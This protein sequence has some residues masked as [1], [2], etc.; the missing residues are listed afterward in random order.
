M[1]KGYI[2]LMPADTLRMYA[3]LSGSMDPEHPDKQLSAQD[4]P[5][6]AHPGCPL[7]QAGESLPLY[8]LNQCRD[9]AATVL[10][11]HLDYPSSLRMAR[12]CKLGNM[13]SCG[14]QG[15][16][17]DV[18][19]KPRVLHV[20]E[21][22]VVEDLHRHQ[23]AAQAPVAQQAEEVHPEETWSDQ[24]RMQYLEERRREWASSSGNG[25]KILSM[26][27]SLGNGLRRLIRMK[28]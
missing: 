22:D 3:F 9:N 2:G 23:L 12:V 11:G 24:E 5:E 27:R 7:L 28:R 1:E 16:T 18:E 17:I 4:F 25:S 19:G 15:S 10:C 21:R 8:Y 6:A 14:V 20:L 13:H 26:F